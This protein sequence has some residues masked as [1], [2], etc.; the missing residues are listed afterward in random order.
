LGKQEGYNYETGG[1]SYSQ[2]VPKN[3]VGDKLRQGRKTTD[4][5]NIAMIMDKMSVDGSQR[6]SEASSFPKTTNQD[7]HN[8]EVFDRAFHRR[9]DKQN[10]KRNNPYSAYVNAMFNSGVF[11]NPWQ[12]QC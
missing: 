1:L 11:T 2:R 7:F 3:L 9:V 4:N 6:P 5:A 8:D 10:F 12:D